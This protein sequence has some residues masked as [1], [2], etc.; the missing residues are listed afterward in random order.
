M[1][2]PKLFIQVIVLS[3]ILFGCTNCGGSKANS[4]NKS[5]EKNPPFTIS[6]AYFQKWV[7]GVEDGGSGINLYFAVEDNKEAVKISRVYFRNQIFDVNGLAV[8]GNNYTARFN[9]EK[10]ND[11]VMDSDPIK[12]AQNTPPDPFPF[13]LTENEAV[14]SYEINGD[15]CFYKISNIEEKPMLAYPGSNG[16]K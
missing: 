11:V 8:K 3:M 16:P 4:E 15:M 9:T 6:N 1:K 10:R 14:I 7:A 5:L 13:S 12:E 2:H